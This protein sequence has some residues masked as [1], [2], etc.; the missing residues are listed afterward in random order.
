VGEI[1]Q[2]ETALA[3]QALD[4]IATDVRGSGHGSI[5]LTRFPSG[6]VNGLAQIVHG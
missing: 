4:P 1:N 2:T 5:G 3:Q 6:F